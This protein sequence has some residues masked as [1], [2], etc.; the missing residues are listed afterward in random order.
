MKKMLAAALAAAI[1]TFTAFAETQDAA[2]PDKNARPKV[3][4]VLAGGGAKGAAHVGVLKYLE[5]QGIPI[6][7][8]AG[9]SMGSIIGGLYALGYSPDEI[10]K[11]IKDVDWSVLMSNSVPRIYE[12]YDVKKMNDTYLVSLPFSTKGIQEQYEADERK[13]IEEE[14]LAE[15]GHIVNQERSS[16]F[17]RSLPGG[18]IEG[19][20]IANLFNNLSVGYQDSIDFKKLPVPYAC[21]ATNLVD[22]SQVVLESGRIAYAMR[23]SMAIPMV[24]A[25][26]QY[27]NML[28]V[29]GGMVNNF[30]TDICRD[31][32][33]D[34]IIG[35]ELT[36]G[37]KADEDELKSIPG[38]FSQLFAIVTSGHN[39]ENR[40]LCD[41]YIRPDVSGYGT[42]SFDA[43]SIDSLVARG[44]KEAGRFKDE[45]EHIKNAVGIAG[46]VT[47][48]YQAEKATYL[49]SYDKLHITSIS[50]SG[51]DQKEARWLMRKWNIDVGK[52]VT[53]D[54][55]KT[56][57]SKYMGT[58]RFKRVSYNTIKDG[59]IENGYRLELQ[60]EPSEPHKL[61][62]GLRAD[63]EMAVELAF[64]L[65]LNENR[66]SGLSAAINGKL[67]Y[68]PYFELRTTYAIR[69]FLNVNL[70]ADYWRSTFAFNKNYSVYQRKDDNQ[71]FRA[72][73]Y[74]SNFYSRNMEF[75]LGGEYERYWCN[76]L[77]ENMVSG[78]L[79]QGNERF[80]L[81]TR[82]VFD[83]RDTPVFGTRGFRLAL[84]GRYTI[85]NNNWSEN[86]FYADA[87]PISDIKLA[88][89]WYITPGHGPITI[90]PQI[91][92]RTLFADAGAPMMLNNTFGGTV[93]DRFTDGQIPFVGV[94]TVTL[95]ASPN[96][97]VLRCD[98]RANLATRHYLTA[99]VNHRMEAP[100]IVDY[101]S[102]DRDLCVREFGF[103]LQYSYNTRL[104]PFSILGE[105]SQIQHKLGAYVSFGYDF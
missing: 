9:T 3:G 79:D 7:Y 10:D 68:N 47:K 23:S 2:V 37:F 50:V 6:D 54:E 82:F 62:L 43:A 60:F 69:S 41:V 8:I 26:T 92:H 76:P 65:G 80:G 103:G 100:G 61:G 15:E 95:C 14:R 57:I 98:V 70:S 67:S 90:I 56:A 42:M 71:R 83:N 94:N 97:T 4:V 51:I 39:A 59:H 5:E 1:S 99:I 24:F 46:P 45:I 55:L 87:F 33:A 81:F 44:Y 38:L 104:G 105:W 74:F 102:S 30:P 85:K 89:E 86:F 25:P 36:K 32:G 58:G 35:V 88:F 13:A 20:N 21:V 84:D 73:F 64:H 52:D 29:D 28:L 72:R 101:F 53:P 16:D 77:M 19:N 91:Y 12:S 66:L 75:S 27:N 93:M 34:Y 48:T 31:M 22:G 18:L 49:D 11:I 63:S 40:K 78:D 96:L 17:L